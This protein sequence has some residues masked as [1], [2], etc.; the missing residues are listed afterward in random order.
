[1]CI[2]ASLQHRT[3]TLRAD[4]IVLQVSN[5]LTAPPVVPCTPLRCV[6]QPSRY[7]LPVLP[8][9]DWDKE[10]TSNPEEP[11]SLQPQNQNN[12]RPMSSFLR[13]VRI[14]HSRDAAREVRSRL[15][16]EGI[17]ESNFLEW[18][19]QAEQLAIRSML[20]PSPP[21]LRLQ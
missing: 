20:S 8:M 7:K 4:Y 16:A 3:V 17:N 18:K 15:Q 12:T 10:I 1:M 11:F 9:E 6:I 2:A 14:I 13:Y 5:S 19:K 21:L